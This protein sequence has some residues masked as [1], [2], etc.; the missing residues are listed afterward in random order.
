MQIDILSEEEDDR[1]SSEDEL[2]DE[3][4]NNKS[5]AKNE[6]LNSVSTEKPANHLVQEVPF[7]K[8]R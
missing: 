4:L 1:E 8:A 3:S 6:R 7:P 5:K 2:A